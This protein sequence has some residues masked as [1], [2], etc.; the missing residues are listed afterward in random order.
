MVSGMLKASGSDGVRWVTDTCN[1]IV[2][3]GKKTDDWKK[4]LMVNVYKS[5]GDALE[6]GSYRGIK[7]TEH[8]M[9]AL[10]RVVNNTRVV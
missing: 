4:C 6:C 2:R 7:L 3:D 8:V 9:K 5:K 1:A 10:E